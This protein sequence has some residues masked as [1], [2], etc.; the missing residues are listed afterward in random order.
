MFIFSTRMFFALWTPVHLTRKQEGLSIISL[1]PF[2]VMP[3]YTNWNTKDPMSP[4]SQPPPF[5]CSLRWTLRRWSTGKLCPDFKVEM[6]K[7]LGKWSTC[8]LLMDY[9]EYVS[10][11][12]H[13]KKIVPSLSSTHIHLSCCEISV[14][15]ISSYINIPNTWKWT[16]SYPRHSLKR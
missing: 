6:Q 15:N 4:H 1:Q 10:M 7:R 12:L 8:E 16:S 14:Y 3:S 13:G 9:V 5:K 2:K 11:M